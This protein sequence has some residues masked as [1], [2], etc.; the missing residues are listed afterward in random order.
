MV[1]DGLLVSM[2]L[3]CMPISVATATLGNTRKA[4]DMLLN[5]FCNFRY[6]PPAPNSS[7]GCTQCAAFQ[8]SLHDH[9]HL[10]ALQPKRKMFANGYAHKGLPIAIFSSFFFFPLHRLIVFH[11]P[12]NSFPLHRLIVF[13]TRSNW[14]YSSQM[15]DLQVRF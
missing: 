8:C 13:H 6:F 4:P 7:C 3:G 12:V 2:G 9:A 1:L 10:Q 15:V 14:D 11:S 5:C